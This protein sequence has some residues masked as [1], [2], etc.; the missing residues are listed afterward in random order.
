MQTSE[1]QDALRQE[2][3]ADG[4][5]YIG[6]ARQLLEEVR[7]L[8]S[9]ASKEV[10]TKVAA[11]FEDTHQLKD[12]ANAAG[13]LDI[14]NLAFQLEGEIKRVQES[15]EFLSSE[16][17]DMLLSYVDSI[18]T[19]LNYYFR[20][21]ANAATI[22]Q[23]MKA[24]EGFQLTPQ[25]QELYLVET[26]EHLNDISTIL[27]NI[28]TR[29]VDATKGLEE[30]FRLV[31]S[32]KG[33][34]NALGFEE[35]ADKSH[36][37]EGFLSNRQ[38][39]GKLEST[40]IELLFAKIEELSRLV[41]R[42]EAGKGRRKKNQ[43]PEEGDAMANPSDLPQATSEF[44]ETDQ[45]EADEDTGDA[46]E[47]LI[48]LNNV[49][50]YAFSAEV[51][52]LYLTEAKASFSRL[53]DLLS[54][55][56][57]GANSEKASLLQ[58]SLI[59]V[60]TLAAKSVALGVSPI[61][62]ALSAAEKSLNK[63]LKN[64]EKTSSR[65][66]QRLRSQY[67]QLTHLLETFATE[68]LV[69]IETPSVEVNM[70]EP[71][72]D[73]SAASEVSAQEES[74]SETETSLP[75]TAPLAFPPH[76]EQ[77]PPA[78]LEIP[79][80]VRDIYLEESQEIMDTISQTLL[81]LEQ[82]KAEVGEALQDIYRAVHTLKGNSNALG[83][84][85]VGDAAAEMEP[86]LRELRDHPD[87]F[88][89][90]KMEHIFWHLEKVRMRVRKLTHPV[91]TDEDLS[92]LGWEAYQP[93]EGAEIPEEVRDIYL[94]ESQ[95]LIETVSQTMLDLEQEKLDLIEAI[96][97]IYRA[98]H[99][100]KGNS[101]ALGV[102]WIGQAAHDMETFMSELRENPDI[103]DATKME[104]LFRY[105][106]TVR[107]LVDQV[108]K[109]AKASAEEELKRTTLDTPAAIRR[110]LDTSPT[111]ITLN[112]TPQQVVAA[113]QREKSLFD[114]FEQKISSGSG[115]RKVDLKT[116]QETKKEKVAQSATP[117]SQDDTI[118]V[119]VNKVD[120]IINLSDELLINKIAYEQRLADIR[121]MLSV[122]ESSRQEMKRREEHFRPEDA[123]EVFSRLQDVFSD[124]EDQI[125]GVVKT[126]KNNNGSF[127]LLVEE[128]Q[129]NSRTT[130]M[131][132][133]SNLVNPLR[134]VVRNT[135]SKLGKKVRLQV[136]GEEIELDRLLIE[137]LKDPLAHILR[138]ALD[139]GIESATERTQA[140]KDAEAVISVAIS[141]SGNNIVFQIHD[142]G[143]GIDFYKV[144]DKAIRLG[145]VTL[146]Q[147]A[148]LS[149][150]DLSQLMFTPGFS[151]ADQVTDI[152]G[153]GVGLDV[154]KNTIEGLNGSVVVVS[155]PQ[156]GTIFTLSLPVTLTTFDAFLV[157]IAEQTFA[158]PRSAVLSTLTVKPGD[159]ADN[160][161]SK[162]IYF[163]GS[164]IKLVSLKNMLRLPGRERDDEEFSALIVESNRLRF[165]LVVDQVLESQ[166]MV[167][168]NLGSQLLKVP[169]IS[170]AT[171]MGSG[172]PVVILNIAEIINQLSSVRVERMS[173][174]VDA[175]EEE[176]RSSKKGRKTRVLVVDDS[177]TTRT[178]EKNILEAAGFEVF[179]GKNGLEGKQ[180][181]L[182]LMP[183][184]DLV[185]T[186][187]EMPKMNG[188]QFAS[189]LK[190]ESEYRNTPLIMVTS[191]ASDEFK[192]K[193]FESG[194]DA[195]IVKGE[196]NQKV[197]LD[198]ISR[199]LQDAA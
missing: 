66:L 180:Q 51:R 132:P 18:E 23:L 65:F 81:E 14:S 126:F 149:D 137:K 9:D 71:D 25:I 52:N 113:V 35:V 172:E 121:M 48:S 115:S 11:L 196:F 42:V 122:V 192:A 94:M 182:N 114:E 134:L 73:K 108:T 141:L 105:L 63:A 153:R 37:L 24:E 185:I 146:E 76:E 99:T 107:V 31:H 177:V 125:N 72:M 183:E 145:L 75:E 184:L 4:Y 40:Q 74:S 102:T 53:A 152:S 79:E 56:E 47:G 3:Q 84:S 156:R 187:V 95:E 167:M 106:E 43:K 17:Q 199:L 32:I 12:K 120:K 62:L 6:F 1:E 176:G 144:R 88:N 39:A 157:E 188:Y 166:Q 55:L 91:K 34:S 181:V 92:V 140:G 112:K 173:L 117:A 97:E 22:D 10:A 136:I 20:N 119:A 161:V 45:D 85:W 64:P 41:D 67:D 128:I 69:S 33:D 96:E 46:Q 189:W 60:Q 164:P 159:L 154:V 86:L 198:T 80:E 57:T 179:I 26:R 19:F 82:E 83:V 103:F 190:K 163:D 138:N 148:T 36:A 8:P 116:T 30:V 44:A 15:S 109:Q 139:H 49:E 147:S 160:G 5:S 90:S 193:G 151:T 111:R 21:T 101:N 110:T 118:R 174:M 155:E 130:R 38:N 143:R 68:S 162:A 194:I 89:P 142:D 2:L 150:H 178:L 98:V 104:R 197:L 123:H 93:E 50:A 13:L 131:L 135:S 54:S 133:A 191:L 61:V 170:G 158:L 175:A 59:T 129:Y 100:L 124:L 169:Y 7:G 58:Q 195:Y 27:L 29:K 87:I 78:D 77:E 16:V 171:L 186:D 168:K 165:A 127:A 70:Q 28:D